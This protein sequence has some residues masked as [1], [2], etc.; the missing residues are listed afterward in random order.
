[1]VFWYNRKPCRDTFESQTCVCQ[2]D[3]DRGSDLRLQPGHQ[4]G[5][6]RLL[7]SFLWVSYQEV[8]V[9]TRQLPSEKQSQ[10]TAMTPNGP[11]THSSSEP[12][13]PPESSRQ[14]DLGTGQNRSHSFLHDVPDGVGFR[15]GDGLGDVIV[16]LQP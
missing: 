11:N 9:V 5:H 1:M 15:S 2:I 3:G 10:S 8:H 14:S 16:V 7:S 4:L 13:S 12:L 6:Q